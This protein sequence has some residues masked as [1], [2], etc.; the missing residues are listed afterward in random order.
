METRGKVNTHT[1]GSIAAL[2]MN[3]RLIMY[4]LQSRLNFQVE[5]TVLNVLTIYFVQLVPKKQLDR[6]VSF[7]GETDILLFD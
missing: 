6:I 1:N 5:D 2:K 3:K 4:L 7:N